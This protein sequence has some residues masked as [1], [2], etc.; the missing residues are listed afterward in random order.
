MKFN[1]R[2]WW[3]HA[4]TLFSSLCKVLP[5]I[6]AAYAAAGVPVQALTSQNEVDTD[7]TENARLHL[8]AGIRNSIRARSLRPLLESSGQATKIWILDHNYNLWGVSGFLQDKS[9][10]NTRTQLLARL[11]WESGDDEQGP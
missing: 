7:Q 1:A 3:L 8:A 6:S 2:C 5:G 11:L 4:Q 9:C 10:A